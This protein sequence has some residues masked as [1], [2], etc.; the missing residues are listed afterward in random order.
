[1]SIKRGYMKFDNDFTIIPN[2]WAR[3]ERLSRKARGLLLELASHRPGWEITLPNLVRHGPEGI[4]AIRGGIN[5]LKDAGYLKVERVHGE[6]GRLQGTDYL[7]QDPF[8][9]VAV[10]PKSA[11]PTQGKPTQGNP[12]PK[13]T[14]SLEDEVSKENQGLFEAPPAVDD[15][16]A[17]LAPLKRKQRT[18]VPDKFVVT[19]ELE[20]WARGNAPSIA[21]SLEFE[22]KKFLAHN[23]AKGTT[24]LDWTAA[25]RNWMLKAHEWAAQAARGKA[26][27]QMS[28]P[29]D[30][31]NGRRLGIDYS[32]PET[33]DGYTAS[34]STR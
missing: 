1:M 3:D 16:G 10:S 19:A 4:E 18:A 9:E 24:Y 34:T 12:H 2:A 8:A 33:D 23:A 30:S 17:N 32:A 15:R 26:G 25:W 5:E 20:Q 11:E 29:S 22:T 31:N 13:K 27:V 7:L 14:M 21:G 28:H 6:G